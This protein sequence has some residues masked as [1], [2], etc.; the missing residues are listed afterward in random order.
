VKLNG[1]SL[2]LKLNKVSLEC[3]VNWYGFVFGTKL[4][5]IG[6]LQI[7]GNI[8]MS[9]PFIVSL[10]GKTNHL[11]CNKHILTN[12]SAQFCFLHVVPVC[13]EL[14]TAGGGCAVES[15]RFEFGVE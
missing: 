4:N 2:C 6:G 12:S 13:L 9:V 14:N 10:H 11:H 3:A 7:T 15:C 8:L 1:T 5:R